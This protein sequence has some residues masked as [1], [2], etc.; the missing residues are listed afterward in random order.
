[1]LLLVLLSYLLT[2]LLR[3]IFVV[4]LHAGTGSV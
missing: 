3:P 1:V 2:A 4:F